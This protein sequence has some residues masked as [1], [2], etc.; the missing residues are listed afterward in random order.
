MDKYE[1]FRSKIATMVIFKHGM[2]LNEWIATTSN[3][4]VKAIYG[5]TYAQLSKKYGG[6]RQ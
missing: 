2:S 3:K 4:E 5:K 6:A 1:A